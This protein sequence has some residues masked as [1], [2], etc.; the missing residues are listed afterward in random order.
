MDYINSNILI[1]G[2]VFFSLHRTVDCFMIKYKE[3]KRWFVNHFISNFFIVS[4]TSED[5]L[6]LLSCTDRCG[7]LVQRGGGFFPYY[8]GR[9]G[10]ITPSE[11]IVGI[12]GALH[13]YHLLV[14]ENLRMIDYMHHYLMLI[15]LAMS[16]LFRAACYQSMFMFFLSGLPGLID[17]GMLALEVNRKT[18][19]KV[20]VYLNNYL[21]AP[22]IIFTMGL[23]W[24]DIRKVSGIISLLVGYGLLYWNATYFNLDVTRSYYSYV[25]I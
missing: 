17:Y 15:V 2:C 16:Y 5:M 18:E 12:T 3:S 13:L 4:V 1:T 25:S 20:N 14:F 10:E 22:G 11:L 6:R 19:K 21:R 23:Y 8:N 24:R 7:E 9:E